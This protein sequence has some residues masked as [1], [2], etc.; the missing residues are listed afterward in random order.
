MKKLFS[1]S[2]LLVFS[3][4]FMSCEKEETVTVLP[5]TEAKMDRSFDFNSDDIDE[6]ASYTLDA[7]ETQLVLENKI[8]E[9]SFSPA[10][11]DGKDAIF[12]EIYEADL[13]NGYVGKYK[14]QSLPDPASGPAKTTYYH[15][16]NSGSGS[17]LLSG[18]NTIDGEFEITSFDYETQLASGKFTVVMKDVTDPTRY[19]ANL[20]DARKC[21]VTVTG[22]FTNLILVKP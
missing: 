11:Q 12:F 17:V 21:D 14:V 2:L 7:D 4:F 10:R 18:G 20:A 8:L 22:E 16:M 15:Y 1:F 3:F 19:N 6:K 13:A 5:E 9:V